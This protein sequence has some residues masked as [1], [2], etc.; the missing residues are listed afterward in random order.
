M[1]LDDGYHLTYCT[2]IHPG[3]SWD[4]AFQNLKT[5]FPPLKAKLSSQKPFGIGLRLSNR[6]SEEL[7]VQPDRLQEFKIWL[8]EQEL[9]VFTMNGFPYGSFHNQSV[10]DQVHS[11]DWTTTERL[12]YTVRLARILA[13]LLPEG[14]EGGISTSPL[15][16][17]PWLLEAD[18]QKV[19][20]IY[21]Q[22]TNHLV[23]LT[24][25]LARLKQATGK[26]IHIDIEPE[27]DGLLENSKEVINYYQEWLVPIGVPHLQE[28]LSLT[29]EEAREA[30][31]EHLQL[32]YDVCHF[33]LAYE[34]PAEAFAKLK[35]AGIRIGKIQLSAALK[36][37]LP[38]DI[39]T[40][41]DIAETMATFAEDTYL[42]QVVE[43]N[44]DGELTQYPDLTFAL[45]HIRKPNA[46]EW[47]TH[48]HVPLFT[49]EYNGLQSTQ[50]DVAEVLR[51]L[52]QHHMTQH[53]EVET[54][55]WDVLPQDLKKDLSLSIQR[56]LEWVIEHI[57]K[58]KHAENGSPE[59]RRAHE[60][61]NR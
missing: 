30:I 59:H 36:T 1:F 14:M 3:E 28:K 54:Y 53:L 42:H 60:V 15:S 22:C 8:Q 47:R 40:R 61:T 19:K 43:K 51:L 39:E 25:E 50:E 12:D 49:Q 45:Q 55:T 5:Y 26:S 29:K 2:N 44:I 6:A 23:E 58:Y 52:Q 17:K 34:K 7:M 27:P 37:L 57:N 33:A 56:E 13:E 21:N 9:Y 38:E 41:A 4:E 16:Y 48:F 20:S 18:D 10:K 24:E 35:H 32:C 31:Y 11:P 46:V